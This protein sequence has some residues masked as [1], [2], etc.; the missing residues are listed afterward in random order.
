MSFPGKRGDGVLR[1]GTRCVL[2]ASSSVCFGLMLLLILGPALLSPGSA[3]TLGGGSASGL[4]NMARLLLVPLA[5]AGVVF[6]LIGGTLSASRRQRNLAAAV[7][8]LLGTFVL[9]RMIHLF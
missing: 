6:G 5:E 8:G 7:A 3:R 9:L 4:H 2:N 1:S